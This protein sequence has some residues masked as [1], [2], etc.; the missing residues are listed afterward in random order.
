MKMIKLSNKKNNLSFK[1]NLCYILSLN[2]CYAN[3]SPVNRLII[4]FEDIQP[5]ILYKEEKLKFL[6]LN[7]DIIH[8]IL[9]D[10]ENI[11]D[12]KDD[13]IDYSFED[14]YYLD[15]LLIENPIIIFYQFSLDLIKK[16]ND[17][18]DDD[19]NK[20]DFRNLILSKIS[21][22]LINNYIDSFGCNEYNKNMLNNIKNENIKIIKKNINI[23]SCLNSKF[24]EEYILYENIDEIYINIIFE[25]MKTDKFSDYEINNIINEQLNFEKI[26]FTDNMLNTLNK[27]LIKEENYITK[28]FISEIKDLFNYKK[29]NFYYIIIKALKSSFYLYKIRFILEAQKLILKII[30]SNS[31]EFFSLI[32]EVN[33]NFRDKIEYIIKIILDSE[34]FYYKYLICKKS[35]HINQKLIYYKNYLFESKKEEIIK[36]EEMIKIKQYEKIDDINEEVYKEYKNMNNIFPILKYLFEE[37]I[38]K[39]SENKIKELSIEWRSLENNIKLRQYNEIPNNYLLKLLHYFQERNNKKEL[40]KIFKEE[41]LNLFINQNINKN[42]NIVEEEIIDSIEPTNKKSEIIKAEKEISYNTKKL[43]NTETSIIRESYYIESIAINN[44]DSLIEEAQSINIMNAIENHLL[45]LIEKSSKYTILEF[46]KIIGGYK[47][48]QSI[49]QLKNNYFLFWGED[50][51]IVIYDYLFEINNEKNIDSY[52][53]EVKENKLNKN[54]L[55]IFPSCKELIRI[56]PKNNMKEKLKFI[57]N[58]ERVSIFE[59]EENHYII[60][61]LKGII[62]LEYLFNN[63][64]LSEKFTTL[65]NNPFVGGIKLNENILAFTSNNMLP[66]GEDKIIF[67]NYKTKT[68]LIEISEYSFV[69]SVNGLCLFNNNKN[70]SN[71]KILLCAC[72]KYKK[73]QKNG[74]LLVN[75]EFKNG[76]INKIFDHFYDT[77][78]YEVSCLCQ[79]SIVNNE[80]PIKGD[81]TNK[82]NIIIIN[83][84]YFFVGGFDPDKRR[85]IIKLFKIIYDND[86]SEIEIQYIQDIEFENND[87]FNGFDQQINCICQSNIFGYIVITC[88]DGKIYLFKRPNIEIY[89]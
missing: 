85:G 47:I 41:D 33:E 18:I 17:L 7:R 35:Y 65:I 86:F 82:N 31:N 77:G 74:I 87:E 39:A 79:I 34:Y 67:F 56:S 63:F 76:Q 49:K 70:D 1:T 11:I 57:S 59:M 30:K 60:F 69:K 27:L 50:K 58:I 3:N 73:E 68:Q 19:N 28:Y 29:I 72:H 88:L 15:L 45:K 55:E 2:N 66:N 14:F 38:F 10:S 78:N 81:V 26:Y 46:N 54:E 25:F 71:R 43:I 5:I 37:E 80:N 48:P 51:K 12:L 83:T 23:F 36:I 42:N 16:L 4:N 89:L 6:Y 24:T 53:C 13:K 9:Y 64:N 32:E 22:D 75:I 21:I 8:S 62:H 52:I 40:L 84:D 44:D 61:G 20:M